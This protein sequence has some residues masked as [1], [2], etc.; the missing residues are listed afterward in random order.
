MTRSNAA[1]I[2][3]RKALITCAVSTLFSVPLFAQT[4][5]SDQVTQAATG[6]SNSRNNDAQRH[7]AGSVEATAPAMKDKI[8]LRGATTGCM[9]EVQLS[10]LAQR[11][12][13]GD[14]VKQFASLMVADHS[15][16][17]DILRAS[18]E[19]QGVMLPNKIPPRERATYERLNALTGE[20][21]DREYVTTLAADH[22][23]NL[24]EYRSE[25]ANT[26]DANLRSAVQDAAS[27]L[28]HHLVLADQIA[29][30]KGVQVSQPARVAA[31]ATPE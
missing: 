20:E 17:I 18:A 9:V 4:S 8:F 28:H 26:Q 11:K 5:E 16:I 19:A 31:S 12:A 6:S 1:H 25:L 22:H 10:E 29:R 30:S 7:E 24:R 14:D 13:S 21:F 15:R 23:R 27:I 2:I 3:L